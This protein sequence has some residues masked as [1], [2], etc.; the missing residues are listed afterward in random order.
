MGKNIIWFEIKRQLAGTAA[1]TA[2]L[3]LVLWSLTAGIYPIFQQNA[4]DMKK[5]MESFPPEFAAAFDLN[6]AVLFNFGGFY[7]FCFTYIG[8]MG[9]IMAA[10]LG[11]AVFSREKRSGCADFLR[12]KPI[13]GGKIFAGKLAACLLL[14]TGTNVIYMA[15]AVPLGRAHD[16]PMLPAGLSLFLTQLV[17]L[18]MG[19]LY[20]VLARRVRSVSGTATLCGFAGFLMTV[21]L[22][23]TGEKALQFA[24]PLKYFEPEK[25]FSGGGF[26]PKYALTGCAV[27][28]ACCTCAYLWETRR[29]ILAV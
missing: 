8:L 9:A 5:I 12:T 19:I 25:V 27:M 26:D 14:L 13:S 29:D 22:N 4:A 23:L 10:W 15:V 24:A 3:G 18:A 21:L 2:A 6:A 28:V 11:I 20:A 17:F 16:T 1:W 7:S